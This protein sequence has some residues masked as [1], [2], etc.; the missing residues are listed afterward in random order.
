MADDSNRAI[1]Q[2]KGLT[3]YEEALRKDKDTLH[4][5]KVKRAIVA[6][7]LKNAKLK[8]DAVLADIV[9]REPISA[10][11]KPPQT[12]ERTP[13]RTSKVERD[14]MRVGT[15]MFGVRVFTHPTPLVID[16]F[17]EGVCRTNN[18]TQVCIEMNL[19]KTVIY[20]MKAQD[21]EFRQRLYAAQTIGIDSW[22]DEAARRAFSGTDRKVFHQGI[23]IDTVKDY[24]DSIAIAM[25]KGAKPERYATRNSNETILGGSLGINLETLSDDELNEKLNMRL[26]DIGSISLAAQR[27]L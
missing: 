18:I 15:D 27:A 14:K 25:L 24:S 4:K 16:L 23:Q 1:A 20:A 19:S 22:E 8:A 10:E 17:L 21:P 13:G 11:S 6:R 26:R 3:A 2:K 9:N 12:D 7:K 5:A